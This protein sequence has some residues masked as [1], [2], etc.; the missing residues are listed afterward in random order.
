MVC[1]VVFIP[2]ST[3]KYTTQRSPVGGTTTPTECT[4]SLLTATTTPTWTRSS[5]TPPRR[6][7]APNHMD[8]NPPPTT[9]TSTPPRGGLPTGQNSTLVLLTPGSRRGS[10]REGL[11]LGQEG[12]PP[13]AGP[14]AVYNQSCKWLP[15]EFRSVKM[16]SS[17]APKWEKLNLKWGG[18]L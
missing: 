4:C 13:E 11:L 14:G 9:W 15:T 5:P 10:R 17:S 6:T 1:C 8:S 2:T 3:S 7:T 18:Q 12:F 16:D